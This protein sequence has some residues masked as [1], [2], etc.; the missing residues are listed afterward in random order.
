MKYQNTPVVAKNDNM[1]KE[2]ISITRRYPLQDV[3]LHFHDF[4]EMEIVSRGSGE[5]IINGTS[6]PY[7]RGA[8][9]LL[10]LCDVHEVRTSDSEFINISF[11]DGMLFE[12]TLQQITLMKN[13]LFF[14]LSEESFE[15]VENL[16][17]LMQREYKKNT[18]DKEYLRYLLAC[19]LIQVFRENNVRGSF[20]HSFSSSIQATIVYLHS[21]F[22]ENP[23]LSEIA[24]HLHYNA[25]YLSRAFHDEVRKS[26]HEYLT[27]LKVRYAARLLLST[28]LAVE[29]I[30]SKSGFMS[31]TAFLSAFKKQYGMTPREYRKTH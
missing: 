8:I 22:H 20:T 11:D 14:S 26:Y 5:H 24:S 21:H 9:A 15:V 18:Y 4:F 19:I 13:D 17:I 12:E 3:P 27:G 29:I 31:K 7:K 28:S 10:R 6:Y 16:A 30:C 1:L 23:R 25:N 2:Q